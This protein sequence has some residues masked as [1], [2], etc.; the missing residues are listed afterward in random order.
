MEVVRR[1]FE[2][3]ATQ[4]GQQRIADPA[5]LPR[6]GAFH[7]PAVCP[8][9][10]ATHHQFVTGCELLHKRGDIAEIIAV[11]GVADDDP[12][13]E[14]RADAAAQRMAVTSLANIDNT[15]SRAARDF[16]RAIGASVV[17]NH[18]LASDRKLVQ[19]VPSLSNTRGKS[20]RLV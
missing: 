16:L 8:W 3:Q 17:G 18:Y 2:K 11:V 13:T 6:H 15:C 19:G 9:H 14:R 5:M 10:P 4:K 12:L 7:D 1:T 20:L